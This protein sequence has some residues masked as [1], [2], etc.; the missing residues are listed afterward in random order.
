MKKLILSIII[1]IFVNNCQGFKPIFS[2]KDFKFNI[3]EKINKSNDNFSRSILKKLEPFEKIDS[4]NNQL[5]SI[6]LILD[7]ELLE[8]TVSKDKKG[9]PLAFDIAVL[10]NAE[11]VINDK[12]IKKKYSERSL[13]NNQSNKF[14]LN[15]YKRNILN[16]MNDKIY[17]KI[18]LD[19]ISLQ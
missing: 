10:V 3:K 7:T 13:Y 2:G 14:D 12:I 18:I 6:S 17:E 19:L 11:Y 4:E 8:R 1:I 5:K 9:N 16:N 15:Q